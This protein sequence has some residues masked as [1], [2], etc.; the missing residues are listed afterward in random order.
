MGASKDGSL[1]LHLHVLVGNAKVFFGR[2][3]LLPD[4]GVDWIGMDDFR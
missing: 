2:H 3:L 1:P 4:I